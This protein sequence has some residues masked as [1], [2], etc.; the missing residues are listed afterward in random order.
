[1]KFIDIYSGT[2]VTN[3]AEVKASGVEGVYIKATD[4]TTYVNPLL[5][6][7]YK[8]AKSVGLLVGFYIFAENGNAL[9]E[10]NHF[11]STIAKY[12]QDLKPSLDYEVTNPDFNFINTFLAQNANLLLYG[13]HSVLDKVNIPD[14]RKWVAEPNTN[15]TGT[16][17][18]AGI[19]DSWVAKIPGISNPQVDQD[20]FDS[21]VLLNIPIPTENLEEMETH[22]FSSR[23]YLL[24]NPD[25]ANAVKEGTVKD[26]FTH[27]INNG[28]KEGRKP[29][30]PLPT[31]F[32]EGAYLT[33]NAG[34]A[35]A[36]IANVYS[37]GAEHYMMDEFAENRKYQ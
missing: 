13:D 16:R 17:G 23:F 31:T 2:N 10:Y 29:C 9:S 34:V 37:C 28:Q 18:Y 26:A 14:S 25:V 20:L 8:G 32:N 7:E 6:S 4:G 19:Q 12:E 30:P 5:D 24:N 36:V 35:K 1:M 21:D 22:M 3:W 11:M 15:P 27:Y 33:N